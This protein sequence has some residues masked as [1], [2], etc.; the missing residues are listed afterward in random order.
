MSPKNSCHV[1]GSQLIK[2]FLK[3]EQ[4][5]VHQN[6]LIKDQKSAIDITRGDLN[7]TVCEECGF[8]FNQTFDLSKLSYGDNYDNT[9]DCSPF[10]NNYTSNLA[11]YLVFDKNIQNCRIVE[12]GCGKGSFLRK[13]VEV[14][15]WGNSGYGFDPSYVG[16]ESQFEGRLNFV[17]RYYDSDCANIAADVVICRHVIEH[18]PEP[19]A[20][21]RTI[22]QAL[23]HSQKARVFFETPSVEWILRNQV[24]WDFFYEHC[25]YFT[26]QSLTTVFEAAGFQVKSVQHVFEDQYLWLEATISSE[27]PL[28]TKKCGS[29][30]LLANQFAAS[31]NDLAKKWKIK[32]RE[33]H[34]KGKVALWGAGAKGVTFVNLIDPERKWIDCVID[35]NISKHGKYIPGT[36]HPIVSYEDIPRRDIKTAILMNPNYYEENLALLNKANFHI[37]LIK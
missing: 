4:I 6:L 24:I 26:T 13:L 19:L 22:K 16:P 17:K 33:F 9:Q 30:P 27:K 28:V 12:V 34:T 3:R 32:I 7:L 31:E 36:G 29:I 25:S 2:R 5:P 20:L 37:N 11:S 21:L 35:L 10:F 8:I 23:I 1:C 14:K 15:E 18:V